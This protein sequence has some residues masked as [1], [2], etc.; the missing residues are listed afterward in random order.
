MADENPAIHR[1]QVASAYAANSRPGNN[2]NKKK[3][4]HP[5]NQNFLTTTLDTPLMTE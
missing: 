4:A 2:A 3:A 1:R 5:M